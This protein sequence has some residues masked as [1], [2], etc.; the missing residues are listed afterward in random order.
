MSAKN[1]SAVSFFYGPNGVGIT[2][3]ML[4]LSFIT[5]RYQNFVYLKGETL[6]RLFFFTGRK[7]NKFGSRSPIKRPGLLS[8]S[9]VKKPKLH[10]HLNPILATR[11][12]RG[13]RRARPIGFSRYIGKPM[14]TP[15]EMDREM[16]LV[17]G[18]SGGWQ[19]RGGAWREKMGWE[20]EKI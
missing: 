4:F 20:R 2:S 10:H 12:S 3:R 1:L 9:I 15:G 19:E 16:R 11:G 18:L 6:F 7:K 14:V 17:L 8:L 5:V 13:P